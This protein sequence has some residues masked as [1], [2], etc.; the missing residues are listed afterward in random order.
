VHRQNSH[1]IDMPSTTLVVSALALLHPVFSAYTLQD[2]YTA[3]NWLTSFSFQAIPDP[4]QGYVTYLDSATAQ[5]IGLFKTLPDG[6]VYMGVDSTSAAPAP[7]RPSLR[8][9]SLKAYTHALVILDLAHMPASTCGTWPAFWTTK[10]DTWP[11]DGEIDIIE[12]VNSQRSNFMTLHTG[13]PACDISNDPS[14]FAAA[15]KVIHTGCDLNSPGQPKNVGCSVNNTL[16]TSYGTGFNAN[17]GGIYAMEWTS[18][19]ISIWHFPHTSAPA[20]IAAASPIRVS[21]LSRQR[22]SRALVTSTTP[23]AITTSFSIRR[24][25]ASGPGIRIGR[26]RGAP[27]RMGGVVVRT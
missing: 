2:H 18:A 7:G 16:P 20:D 19:H 25:V 11:T 27:R 3:T 13:G 17:G 23:S 14:N 24:S 1:N 22:A 8:M 12:G 21:G 4:T 5:K 6:K 9:Q 10:T 15:S 26:R